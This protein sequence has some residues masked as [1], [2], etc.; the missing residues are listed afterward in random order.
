[1][2]PK[3]GQV[4]KCVAVVPG[5]VSQE[6]VFDVFSDKLFV[7]RNRHRRALVWK[8]DALELSST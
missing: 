7:M 5:S 3:T 6:Y 8:S 2:H 4:H 1:M